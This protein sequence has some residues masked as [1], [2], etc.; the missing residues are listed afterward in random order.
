MGQVSVMGGHSGDYWF[1]IAAC[2]SSQASVICCVCGGTIIDIVVSQRG[3]N[4]GESG[5]E[6]LRIELGSRR[7]M[8]CWY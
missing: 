6:V 4:F 8:Q 2:K 5:I 7:Q 1:E 3:S